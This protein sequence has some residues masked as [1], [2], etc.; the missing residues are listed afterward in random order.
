MVQ[1]GKL[2]S[3]M[4]TL[5]A[6]KILRW[7]YLGIF[8]IGFFTIVLLHAVPKPFLDII[9]MPTF[10]RAAEPYLG[11]SYD[12]S[13][14]FYQIILLSFFLIVLIDAV[15]LFFLSSNLIKKISSTFSFVG[16]ILIGL[17]IT[18]FLY[19]LLIIG[20][21]SILTKTILIYLVVSFSLFTLDLYTFW[22]DEDLI[23]HL[24]TRIVANNREK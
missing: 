23:H 11:F 9:R 6:V 1:Q 2:K 21:D 17:V 13:L 15:S 12:P 10:I 7:V 14:L 8:L 24:P 16:V 20:A 3:V 19:S 5:L 4:N 18:Y 22:L